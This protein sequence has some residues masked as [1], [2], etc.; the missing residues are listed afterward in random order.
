MVFHAL[1]YVMMM[2]MMIRI[3]MMMVM[4]MAYSTSTKAVNSYLPMSS[5]IGV[6]PRIGVRR[7]KLA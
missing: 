5:Q 1:V 4:M 6:D 3:K 2:M 7:I